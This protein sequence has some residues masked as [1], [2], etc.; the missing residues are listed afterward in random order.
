MNRVARILLAGVSA[1]SMTLPVISQDVVQSGSTWYTDA[2]AVLQ[3]KIAAQ[4]NTGKAKNVILFV[5]D[6]QGVGTN[7]AVRLFAGQLEGKLGEEHVLPYETY[8]YTALIKTYNI[9]AQTPDS[10]PTAG[11]MNS[12]IKQVFNTINLDEDG[13]HDNCASEEGNKVTLFSEIASEG[14]KSVGVVSTA[15]ATHATPAAVYAKTANRNWEAEAPEGCTDIA[16]QAV[17]AME[18]GTIDV[19]LAGGARNFYATGAKTVFGGDSSRKDDLDLVARAQA[20]GAQFV[21]DLP[22]LEGVA[23]GSPLLGLFTDSDMSYETERPE[24]EPS[25]ADMTVAAIKALEGNENGFYLMVEG[26]RVDHANHAGNANRAF[27][28]G[29]A[30]AKAVALADEMTNDEDTLI[31]VTADHEHAIAF[32]GYCGRGTPITG[33]CMGI[34]GDGIEHTGEPELADDGKPYSVVGYLNG[35]GSVLTQQ[36]DGSYFGTRP[37]VTQEEALDVDYLQQALIPMS[38]ETHSGEDVAAWAKG[39]WAHLLTGTQEQNYIFHV[40]NHAVSAE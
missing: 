29:V 22:G 7:Y 30:F 9:N 33:L 28:D 4:P 37:N 11:A 31:I 8:P 13:R 25:V 38:G 24:T 3:A 10:A 27:M 21:T 23:A 14:G 15:R 26:G 17:E 6:G 39:P 2:D 19:L 5:A 34:N 16:V 12:G 35:A 20:A 40:M 1:V 18:A 32:N 36:A